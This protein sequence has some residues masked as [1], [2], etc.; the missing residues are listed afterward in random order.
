MLRLHEG[1]PNLELPNPRRPEEL[2]PL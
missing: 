2:H 1:S